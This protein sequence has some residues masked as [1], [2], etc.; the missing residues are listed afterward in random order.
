MSDNT[1]NKLGL[2]ILSNI[3]SCSEIL[4]ISTILGNIEYDD[5]TK[6][7]MKKKNILSFLD[8]LK[9]FQSKLH[10]FLNEGKISYNVVSNI[11]EMINYANQINYEALKTNANYMSNQFEE[12]FNK[13]NWEWKKLEDNTL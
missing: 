5:D 11:D 9:L 12:I 10:E 4:T 6:E 7:E 13:C 2:D 1:N 3:M 8:T